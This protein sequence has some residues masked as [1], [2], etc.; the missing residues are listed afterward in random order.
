M[1]V[2][3]ILSSCVSSVYLLYDPVSS[4][5]S[6]ALNCLIIPGM[7]GVFTWKGSPS[8]PLLDPILT[9]QQL[10]ALREISLA[11]EIRAA[12]VPGMNWLYMGI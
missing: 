3:D 1:G 7:E 4:E 12:G 11:A 6:Q 9:K 10:S 2:I 5:L 8:P